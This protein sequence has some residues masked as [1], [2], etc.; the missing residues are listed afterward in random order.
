MNFKLNFKSDDFNLKLNFK[1]NLKSDEF[2][3]KLKS[4]S[5]WIINLLDNPRIQD[6]RFEFKNNYSTVISNIN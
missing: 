6:Q 5:D 3:P 4:K 2:N 1:L